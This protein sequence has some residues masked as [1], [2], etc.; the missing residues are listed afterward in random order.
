MEPVWR[1]RAEYEALEVPPEARRAFGFPPS[2]STAVYAQPDG[3]TIHVIA[4]RGTARSARVQALGAAV[5]RPDQWN[6]S[7]GREVWMLTGAAARR[8]VADDEDLIR[9]T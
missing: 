5:V 3:E 4:Y 9:S 7:S 6:D 2:A 1:V 8:A